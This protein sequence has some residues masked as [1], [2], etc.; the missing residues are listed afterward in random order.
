MLLLASLAASVVAESVVCEYKPVMLV[1]SYESLVLRGVR[2]GGEHQE[3]S[4]R[5]HGAARTN[6]DLYDPGTSVLDKLVVGYSDS[7]PSSVAGGTL[8]Y[9]L[10]SMLG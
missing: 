1:E 4:H 7:D 10:V 5:Y 6:Q 9:V 2:A 3:S 8:C